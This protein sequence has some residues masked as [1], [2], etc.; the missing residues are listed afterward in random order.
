M[1]NPL[2]KKSTKIIQIVYDA[3]TGTRGLGDD[4]RVYKWNIND[5]N[6][7]LCGD[8]DGQLWEELK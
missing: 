2:K 7:Y 8:I 5:S 3:H 1:Q 6:W 4:S